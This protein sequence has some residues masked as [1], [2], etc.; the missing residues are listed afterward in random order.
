MGSRKNKRVVRLNRKRKINKKRLSLLIIVVVLFAFWIYKLTQ[1]AISLVQNITHNKENTTTVV[2]PQA[3]YETLPTEVDKNIKKKYTIL[4]DPGHGGN[5]KGTIAQDKKTFEK[6]L[7]LEIGALVAKKLTKQDDIQ[8]IISRNE[9]KYISLEDR[10][11]LTNEQNVD[12]F[13]SIHLNGQVGGTDATGIE[14]YYVAGRDDGS[15][16][17]AE[18]IQNTVTSYIN[19]RNRGAKT[20][21]FQVLRQSKMASVLIECGFLSNNQEAKKLQN[22]EYQEDLAEGIAQGILS[23]LDQKSS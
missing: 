21:N 12:L 8:V 17:L 10:A 6:D 14:T 9:D 5:D 4:I 19:I 18:N 11:K 3:E 16:Q 2:S 7:T 22:K 15:E 13:V 23:Y 1:G 20:A